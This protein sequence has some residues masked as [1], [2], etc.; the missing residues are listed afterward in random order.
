MLLERS[1]A[2]CKL[3]YRRKV[4]LFRGTVLSFRG[5]VPLFWGTVLK[6][7]TAALYMARLWHFCRKSEE[8]EV[9]KRQKGA[10][11]FERTSTSPDWAQILADTSEPA[12][13]PAGV[14]GPVFRSLAHT[15]RE[16][17]N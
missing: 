14:P 16:H 13:R 10:G 7:E 3:K 4:P 5:A 12:A 2:D 1:V 6:N 11:S 15:L 9:T 8:V 17:Q